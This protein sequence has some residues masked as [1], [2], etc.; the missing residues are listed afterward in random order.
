MFA[1][2]TGEHRI[3]RS[4]LYVYWRVFLFSSNFVTAF[5]SGFLKNRK[6]IFFFLLQLIGLGL[7][8][9]EMADLKF[10]TVTLTNNNFLDPL[11]I[12]GKVWMR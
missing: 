10:S 12:V 2:K 9:V 4:S 6:G 5:L 8:L 1:G 7:R 11:K 3:K